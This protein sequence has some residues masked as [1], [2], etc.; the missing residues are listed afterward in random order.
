MEIN[1]KKLFIVLLSLCFP[2]Y[3]FAGSKQIRTV[4]GMAK[5][6]S[7]DYCSDK[8]TGISLYYDADHPTNTTTACITGSTETVT[9]ASGVSASTT[10]NTTSGGTYGVLTT[11]TA[12]SQVASFT[13]QGITTTNGRVSFKLRTLGTLASSMYPLFEWRTTEDTAEITAYLQVSGT[14][15]RI[16]AMHNDGSQIITNLS[17]YV[18]FDVN[19]TWDVAVDWNSTT[20]NLIGTLNGVS[21]TKAGT[22][23]AFTTPTTFKLFKY[24]NVPAGT[25][26]G[27]DDVKMGASTQ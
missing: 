3:S 23:S 22:I 7:G 19:Q 16:I 2:V 18:S 17:N 5:A 21:S 10:V 12:S 6:A 11:G 27:I 9:F 13:A 24:G 8:L 15:F 26:Y 25:S 4:I 14:T 1:M 20:G